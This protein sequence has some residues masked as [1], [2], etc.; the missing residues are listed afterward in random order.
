MVNIKILGSGCP[1]CERLTGLCREIIKENNIEARIEKVTDIKKFLEYG[2]LMTPGL[3]IN[4]QLI[5]SGKIPLKSVLVNVIKD[6]AGISF[7]Y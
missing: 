6:A 7:S 5:S 4:E 1:S 3:V 2:L